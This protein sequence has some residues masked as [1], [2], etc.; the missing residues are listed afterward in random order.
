[1]NLASITVNALLEADK[2]FLTNSIMQI[3]PVCRVERRP[4]GDDRPGPVTRQLM[5]ALEAHARLTGA[6]AIV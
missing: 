6:G 2:V 5:A 4:I 3:M 1:M